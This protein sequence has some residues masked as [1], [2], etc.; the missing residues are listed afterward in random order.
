M[1]VGEWQELPAQEV[2][3]PL[4]NKQVE[5]LLRLRAALEALADRDQK[6]IAKLRERLL[7]LKHGGGV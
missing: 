6:Q 2:G 1:K 3:A 7:I 4:L 5:A